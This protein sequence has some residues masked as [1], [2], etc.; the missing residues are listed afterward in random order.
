MS[1]AKRA[2]QHMN[3]GAIHGTAFNPA[4]ERFLERLSAKLDISDTHYEAAERSYR[5]VGDW[6]R[7][8]ASAVSAFSP[9]IYTQGS[10]RLG[11]V[12][13][14]PSDE[15][16]FDLDLVCQLGFDKATKTQEQVKQAVG[17]ELVAYCD[18][19]G[20]K[21]PD[22]ERYCWT[23]RYAD[24][25]QFQLDVLPAIP[26]GASQ[27]LLLEARSLD[28][29]WA[30]TAIGLTNNMHPSYRVIS[31]DWPVSNPRGYSDWFR[32]QMKVA[33]AARRRALA[34]R[35]GK[36]D[37]EQ[38]PEYRVKTPLQAVV[39]ILKR[40]RD[41]IFAD[42][43]DT[44]PTS[45]VVTTLAAQAYAQEETIAA[46]LIGVLARMDQHIHHRAGLPWIPNPTDVRENFADKWSESP[47]LR[48]AFHE[49]L[50]AVRQDFG[51]IAR[52][53][54]DDLIVEQLAP[55]MGRGLVEKSV[56]NTTLV[57][58]HSTALARLL[59][60]PHKQALKWP[61]LSGVWTVK[62]SSATVYRNGFRPARFGSNG[63]ALA[64]R[65]GLKFEADTNV[66]WPY[67]VYWQVVNTGAEASKANGLRGSFEQAYV[68]R[69]SL[70]KNETT[71]YSGTHSIECFV[72]KDA[73]CV[74]QSGPFVVNIK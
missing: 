57:P 36:A 59:A 50:Q 9:S 8:P 52:L 45:I 35:E 16:V 28:S 27:R 73:Y 25:A 55:S 51:A 18:R 17:R 61:L 23:M 43:P 22:E 70:S 53:D 40:H 33:F 62:F 14:P 32:A 60:A 63:P 1:K 44:R 7:R 58:R 69:G 47:Q 42:R 20:M 56:G 10:F 48:E 2:I 38:I 71:L 46:T 19:Y 29:T 49:W 37:V 67:E 24:S 31:D 30:D 68:G 13:R 34:L 64:K 6:L 21:R 11:T 66:P 39:Q 72:V 54:S 12:V 74:A 3:S 5:S 65:S 4:A 15:D 41:G 26:D